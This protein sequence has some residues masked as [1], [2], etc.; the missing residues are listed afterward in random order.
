MNALRWYFRHCWHR[1]KWTWIP[2]GDDAYCDLC[3]YRVKGGGREAWRARVEQM[4][5]ALERA[6]ANR[7][8]V[9]T[10]GPEASDV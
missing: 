3:H 8:P 6:R 7:E 1:R 10:N 5:D 2:D 4:A 9:V